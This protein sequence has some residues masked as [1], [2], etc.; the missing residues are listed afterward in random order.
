[1]RD[2]PVFPPGLPKQATLYIDAVFIEG[3]RVGEGKKLESRKQKLEIRKTKSEE[4]FLPAVEM[5]SGPLR[6]R[7]GKDGDV[8]SPLQEKEQGRGS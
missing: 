7:R 6:V 8:K 5:T 4:R 2:S 1:M 3:G